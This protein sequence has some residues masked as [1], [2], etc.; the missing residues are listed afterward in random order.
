MKASIGFWHGDKYLGGSVVSVK[1]EDVTTDEIEL[2]RRAT[3]RCCELVDRES[4][5]HLRNAS[6]KVYEIIE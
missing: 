2:A 6:S 3:K 1:N 4:L 5:K